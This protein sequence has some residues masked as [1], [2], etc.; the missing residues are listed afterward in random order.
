MASL[1]VRELPVVGKDDP[2]KVISLVSRKI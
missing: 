2:R 1:D